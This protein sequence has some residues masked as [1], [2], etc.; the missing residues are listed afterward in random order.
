[1]FILFEAN[2]DQTLKTFLFAIPETVGMLA[3]GIGLVL[4][5]VLIRW[6]MARDEQHKRDN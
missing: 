3:F 6:F 2:V 5:V 4:A 1:M